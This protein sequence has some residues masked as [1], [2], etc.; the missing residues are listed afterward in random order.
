[1]AV[2]RE[3]EAPTP[4]ELDGHDLDYPIRSYI[5]FVSPS[6]FDVLRIPLLRGRVFT[7]ADNDRSARVV[8]VSERLARTLWPS[9]D[10]IGKLL[11]WPG[12]KNDPRPPLRV[13]GVV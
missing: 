4:E 3:G 8:I 9:S 2:F 7:D 11:V 13:V 6:I 10:P 12:T 1:A 5:D